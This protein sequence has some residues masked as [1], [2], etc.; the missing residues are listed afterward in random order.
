VCHQTN[1]PSADSMSRSIQVFPYEQGE[2]VRVQSVKCRKYPE[3]STPEN[4]YAKPEIRNALA[5]KL[6]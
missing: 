1:R 2:T 5:A 3:D 6:S 4:Q